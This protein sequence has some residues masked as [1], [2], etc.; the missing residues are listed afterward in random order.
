M[1][2]DVWVEHDVWLDENSRLCQ[3]LP[4][5]CS[6]AK[7]FQEKLQQIIFCHRRITAASP[8]MHASN[9][10][11]GKSCSFTRCLFTLTK[12]VL[13]KQSQA[14][15]F[16]LQTFFKLLLHNNALSGNLTC[17][18]CGNIETNWL[19]QSLLSNIIKS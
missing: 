1:S 10:V 11:R 12:S 3:Q 14:A 17:A 5:M 8:Q 6:K 16:S 2:Q 7:S 9:T 19:F 15:G 18:P 13:L 4:I